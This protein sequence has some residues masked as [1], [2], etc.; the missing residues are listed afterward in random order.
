MVLKLPI[1]SVGVCNPCSGLWDNYLICPVV[2]YRSNTGGVWASRPWQ[3]WFL[4]SVNPIPPNEQPGGGLRADDARWW[5]WQQRWV[6]PECPGL[7]LPRQLI[8]HAQIRLAKT[9]LSRTV[10]LNHRP[11]KGLLSGESELTQPVQLR[12]ETWN[13]FSQGSICKTQ[14][15][16]VFV[17]LCV[18]CTC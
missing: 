8:T 9:A 17:C 13:C 15:F 10:A 11:L 2:D 3:L 7:R 4:L 16:F 1:L 18:A 6:V 12:P 5:W 14:N